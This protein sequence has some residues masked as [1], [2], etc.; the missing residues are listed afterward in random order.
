MSNMLAVP[1]TPPT[2]TTPSGS[3]YVFTL[4]FELEEIGID[5]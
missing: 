1:A 5:T 2:R 4:R 3:Q